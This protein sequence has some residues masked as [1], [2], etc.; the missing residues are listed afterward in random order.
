V[1]LR[2]FYEGLYQLFGLKSTLVA[3]GLGTVS[4]LGEGIG[5]YF[6]LRGL[7]LP[8][9]A[10]MLSVAVFVLAFSTVVGAVSSLPGGLG[11]AEASIAGMLLFTL[12]LPQDVAATATLLIRFF[13][14]WFGLV[15][16][17]IVLFSSRQLLLFDAPAA[18]A[19]SAG[20]E[21]PAA[22]EARSQ[23]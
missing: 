9:S 7:G 14:L 20:R 6:V 15:L 23:T 5:F 10:E 13:T 17:L 22:R 4:W 3:V 1:H 2:E 8:P 18:D 11:A 19:A 12:A 16:G 21:Q